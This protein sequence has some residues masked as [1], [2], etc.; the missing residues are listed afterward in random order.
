MLAV[1]SAC[2]G[3]LRGSST[4]GV[5]GG[6]CAAAASCPPSRASRR[7]TTLPRV[8]SY[9]VPSQPGGALEPG[10][11]WGLWSFGPSVL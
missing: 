11:V 4:G 5:E 2:L 3:Y 1:V 8:H 6:G 10:P 7:A 9:R